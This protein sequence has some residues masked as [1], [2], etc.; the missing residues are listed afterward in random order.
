MQKMYTRNILHAFKF[1]AKKMSS[2]HPADV[3]E[4]LDE[5]YFI[6]CVGF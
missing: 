5:I 3:R 6:F 1:P 4:A 2:V